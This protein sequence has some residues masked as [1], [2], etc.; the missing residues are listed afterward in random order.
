MNTISNR[1]MTWLKTFTNMGGKTKRIKWRLFFFSGFAGIALTLTTIV[2][3]TAISPSPVLA[4]GPKEFIDQKAAQLQEHVD[5]KAD[6]WIDRQLDK[7]DKW[8]EK[9]SENLWKWLGEKAKGLFDA[10][11]GFF[12]IALMF[13]LFLYMC[14]STRG[15][16]WAYWCVMGYVL[17][18]VFGRVLWGW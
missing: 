6:D 9:R 5:K 7:L 8:L 1:N 17:L 18:R 10:S 12:L 2:A 16:K 15:G 13:C 14:G 4:A 11:G 3:A